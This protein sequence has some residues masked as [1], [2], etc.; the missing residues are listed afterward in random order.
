MVY[1]KFINNLKIKKSKNIRFSSVKFFSKDKIYFNL[2]LNVLENQPQENQ[3][4][5]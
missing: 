3:I 2:Y 1:L 5:K 4:C